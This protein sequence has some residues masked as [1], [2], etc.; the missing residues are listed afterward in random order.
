M[1]YLRDTI[2]TLCLSALPALL[3]VFVPLA[4]IW[5]EREHEIYP[6]PFGV[7]LVVPAVGIVAGLLAGSWWS[8]GY[9]LLVGATWVLWSTTVPPEGTQRTPP[10]TRMIAIVAL[11]VIPALLSSALGTFIRKT[12]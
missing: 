10:E 3:G 5:L 2:K 11:G 4:L 6:G 8:L 12:R 7:L 1:D 9:P